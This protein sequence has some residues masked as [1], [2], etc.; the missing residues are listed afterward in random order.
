VSGDVA[1]DVPVPPQA[2]QQITTSA[3]LQQLDAG[4]TTA[5]WRDYGAGQRGAVA[6]G[7]AQQA[8]GRKQCLFQAS[9][10]GG[11]P[12]PQRTY[13]PPQTAAKLCYLNLFFGRDNELQIYHRN[14]ILMDNKHRK[15]F[16]IKQPKVQIYA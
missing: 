16:V 9:S 13:N 11:I 5:Q 2:Q 6:P 3:A 10:L 15:L 4:R 8:S 7:Q 1:T 12:H 14:F